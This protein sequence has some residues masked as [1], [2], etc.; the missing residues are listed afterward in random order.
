MN[1][2]LSGWSRSKSVNDMSIDAIIGP[3]VKSRRPTS[4]GPMKT[5][6]QAASR[7]LGESF[8]RLRPMRGEGEAR[9]S[10]GCVMASG[11]LVGKG[12]SLGSGGPE[13]AR[14]WRGLAYDAGSS[15][16]PCR[17]VFN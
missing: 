16:M 9:T 5:Y 2:Q 17:V 1:F 13:G 6:P 4:H 3:A 8:Q 10:V 11:R 15:K 7:V 12:G 14:G